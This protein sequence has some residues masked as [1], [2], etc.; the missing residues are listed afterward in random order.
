MSMLHAFAMLCAIGMVGPDD[1]QAAKRLAEA[2]RRRIEA[3]LQAQVQFQEQV[4]IQAQLQFALQAQAHVE[5][6]F[7]ME[8]MRRMEEQHVQETRRARIAEAR[9]R[10]AVETVGGPI[11]GDAV[12]SS[13]RRANR[14]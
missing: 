6:H 5:I 11:I 3:A 4:Q 8:D 10:S 14:P 7:V 13:R 1:D 9:L 12:R 2:E